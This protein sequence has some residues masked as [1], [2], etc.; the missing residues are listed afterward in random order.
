MT[1]AMTGIPIVPPR[2]VKS[3]DPL[4]ARRGAGGDGGVEHRLVERREAVALDDRVVDLR[5]HHRG[6]QH[7]TAADEHGDHE[8]RGW[9]GS[10]AR[11]G[12]E[13]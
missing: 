13:P 6:G 11:P 9:P 7:D 2:S 10:S 1:T 5:G 12:R 8:A 3:G 4:P